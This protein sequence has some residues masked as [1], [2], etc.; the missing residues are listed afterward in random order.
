MRTRLALL[1]AGL[2]AAAVTLVVAAAAIPL[3]TPL[4]V[5][6]VTSGSMATSI[7]V[8]ALVLTVPLTGV[9]GRGE[10]ILFPHPLGRT[11]VVHRVVGVEVGASGSAYVTR[12][13]A[14]DAD[15]GWRISTTAVSG[16]VVAAVPFAGYV[17]GTLQ[18][19]PARIGIGLLILA[20]IL[21]T[22][23][24]VARRSPARAGRQPLVSSI[25]P[26]VSGA[27]ILVTG[28]YYFLDPA[29]SIVISLIIAWQA[30][31][32]VI[33]STNVLLESTPAHVDMDE[34]EQAMRSVGGVEGVHDLHVWSLSSEVHAL[35]AHVV[36]DGH[37]SLEQA[38]AV[39]TKVKAAVS[40]PFGVAHATLEL[41]CEGCVDDGSWC[42][43]D[44][45]SPPASGHQRTES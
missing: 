41:E 37:P 2:A 31:K 14:N 10:V 22:L 28:R 18:R 13:D 6:I 9:A 15:D 32:L 29:M 25:L 34:L 23:R 42:A 16:R 30:W 4:R 45:L 44:A 8:G 5:Q 43:M 33:A 35:S 36:L 11:T 39:G 27:V 3:V 21:P 20:L 40:A 1:P 38:Q 26:A 7:P 17:L 19:P 12:G 24:V